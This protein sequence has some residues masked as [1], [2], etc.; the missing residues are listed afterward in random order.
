[1][2]LDDATGSVDSALRRE[3]AAWVARRDA[4]MTAGER[5]EFERWRRADLRHA[6]ALAQ[7]EGAWRALATP[8]QSGGGD[9]LEAELASL[10]R[11]RRRRRQRLAVVSAAVAIFAL[12]FTLWQPR[13]EVR[14]TH[15]TVA[16][17]LPRV[18]TLADGSRVELNTDAEIAV[19]FTPGARRVVL[20][21]GEAHFAV[22]KDAARPFIVSVAGIEVRAV[23]TAFNVQLAAA[24]VAVLVTEGTVAV[25]KAA[26]APSDPREAQINIA[27]LGAGQQVEVARAEAIAV[28]PQTLSPGE[29]AERLAWRDVR[30]EFTRTPLP[31][32]VALFN[33]HASP[34]TP[35]LIASDPA[36]AAIEVT[37]IFRADNVAGFVH[38]MES[39]FALRAVRASDTIT[40]HPAR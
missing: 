6:V 9:L 23:G 33:R 27:V 1:M 13:A 40:L 16:V 11:D 7:C 22:Q 26:A 24:K 3:A 30:V 35:R 8:A 19:Q 28:A 4:G 10:A 5:E 32:A 37:G 20:K 2:S 18:E 17:L 12:G 39:G 31:E 15:P 25:E 21:R 38:L 14:E 29:S 36:L 34:R